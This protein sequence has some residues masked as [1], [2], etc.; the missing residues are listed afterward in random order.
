M[1]II[2]QLVTE[3]VEDWNRSFSATPLISTIARLIAAMVL[4][5]IIGF[6]R[7]V[8]QKSAGLRT[9]IMIALA[10]CL[11]ALVALE[12][13]DVAS[14]ESQGTAK[15][16]ILRLIEAVT[17]GVAFLAAGSIITSGGKVRGLTTGAGMWLAGAVGLSCGTGRIGLAL[18]A[19]VLGIVVLSLFKMLS[20]S[21]QSKSPDTEE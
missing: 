17:A 8:H 3:L 16:D 6:E 21:I 19:T 14:N 2:N 10:S 4:G 5:G 9:H 20:N 11:F 18:I 12:L 7:E 13:L 15:P 1:E